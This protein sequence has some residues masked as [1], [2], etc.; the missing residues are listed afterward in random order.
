MITSEAKILKQTLVTVDNMENVISTI[1]WIVNI[2]DGTRVTK[3]AGI[4]ELKTPTG[5]FIEFSEVTEAQKL[6]WAFAEHRGQDAFVA[7]V[8]KVLQELGDEVSYDIPAPPPLQ[9]T[10]KV[11][12]VAV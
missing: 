2:N 7:R 3:H 5:S 12:K 1:E 6:E 10:F 8:V 4:S 9:E 11:R